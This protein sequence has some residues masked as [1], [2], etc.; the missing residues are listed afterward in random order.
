MLK[1]LSIILLFFI[2]ITP[3]FTQ[4]KVQDS[5]KNQSNKIQKNP[6]NQNALPYLLCPL[7]IQFNPYDS[8]AGYL[9]IYHPDGKL[10]RKEKIYS[11]QYH[12]MT[13]DACDWSKETFTVYLYSDHGVALNMF[14]VINPPQNGRIG[15]IGEIQDLRKHRHKWLCRKKKW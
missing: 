5:I 2:L 6:Q 9:E 12:F 4:T 10:Y 13:W 8:V 3:G 14:K 7:E 1:C 15:N 11:P